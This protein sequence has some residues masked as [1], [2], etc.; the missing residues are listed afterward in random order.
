MSIPSKEIVTTIIG[1]NFDRLAIYTPNGA[2]KITDFPDLIPGQGWPPSQEVVL[3]SWEEI[4]RLRD[5]LNSL[6]PAAS[7]LKVSE[8]IQYERS[9]V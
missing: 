2:L 4:E 7:Q 9:A 6:K 1:G 5:F 3:R 8:E